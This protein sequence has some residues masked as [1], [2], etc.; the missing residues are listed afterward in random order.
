MSLL[1]DFKYL[2]KNGLKRLFARGLKF[3]WS[4]SQADWDLMSAAEKAKYDVAHV[5]GGQVSDV[6]RR[7]AWNRAVNVTSLPYAAP[8]DGMIVGFSGYGSITTFSINGVTISRG[9]DGSDYNQIQCI[10]SKGDILNGTYGTT[11]L[12]FVPFEDS[13]ISDPITITPEYIRNQNVLSDVEAVSMT[14][15][16]DYT[17][18]YAGEMYFEVT[19]NGGL[20]IIVNGVQVQR[21]YCLQST[22]DGN[23]SITVNKGDIVKYVSGSSISLEYTKA[24]WYKLRDYGA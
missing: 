7:P 16:T 2:S 22:A 24:R 4:G 21:V 10:V 15:N 19:G 18:P 3:E 11:M 8:C 6:R 12:S 14:N 1:D 13:T 5:T 9:I 20:Q 17:C 23:A